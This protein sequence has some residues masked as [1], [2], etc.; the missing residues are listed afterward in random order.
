M[1]P[2]PSMILSA[3]LPG[4]GRGL[5]AERRC[6]FAEARHPQNLYCQSVALR[7]R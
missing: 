5:L 4:A 1:H 6:S 7:Q 2:P 3:K